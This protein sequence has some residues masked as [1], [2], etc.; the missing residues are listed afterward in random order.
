MASPLGAHSPA[1]LSHLSVC[2]VPAGHGTSK[3]E[4][5]APLVKSTSLDR[6]P[7]S[8]RPVL[9]VTV[10]ADGTEKPG[11]SAPPPQSTSNMNTIPTATHMHTRLSETPSFFS[12]CLAQDKAPCPATQSQPGWSQATQ[13][14]ASS[15]QQTTAIPR[16]LVPHA[17]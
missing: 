1:Q 9:G 12:H 16:R 14:C 7:T 17:L 8:G 5:G 2:R 6:A 11:P 4:S 13:C 3:P 15:Y 10:Q